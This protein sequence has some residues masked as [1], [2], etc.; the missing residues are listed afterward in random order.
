MHIVHCPVFS[1][2]KSVHFQINL[3]VSKRAAI[4]TVGIYCLSSTELRA[5]LLPLCSSPNGGVIF[6]GTP[7][8]WEP[9]REQRVAPTAWAGAEEERGDPWQRSPCSLM[10]QGLDQVGYRTLK[11]QRCWS[12]S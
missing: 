6:A 5:G 2:M 12:P 1:D 8:A 3:G 7:P 10:C 9:S 4:A 11:T